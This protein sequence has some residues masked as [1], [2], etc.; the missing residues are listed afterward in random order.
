MF[1]NGQIT[2]VQQ[3]VGQKAFPAKTNS[4]EKIQ[5]LVGQIP[6]GHNILIITKIKDLEEA[7][8]YVNETIVNGWSRAILR[9]QIET[10][11][12]LRQGKATTNFDI[13]L[14]KPQSDLAN[15]TLKDTYIFDILTI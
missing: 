5:Q 7:I 13:T 2:K 11:L 8:F 4:L 12:H 14:P 6:W 10:N 9:M 1:Y 15:Q 3:V